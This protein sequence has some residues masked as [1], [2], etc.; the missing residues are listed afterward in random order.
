[1][2]FFHLFFRTGALVS[3]LFCTL[4]SDS[5]VLNFVIIVLLLA[6]DFWTVK[7]VSGRLLVGLR[8]WNHVDANGSSKWV[9]ESAKVSF[10]FLHGRQ[11]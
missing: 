2:V 1:V 11:R 10:W 5:F 6:L 4:F 7:N 9:F 8:W 3:Y